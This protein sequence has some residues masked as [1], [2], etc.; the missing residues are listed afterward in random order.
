MLRVQAGDNGDVVWDIPE[1]RKSGRHT[2]QDAYPVLKTKVPCTPDPGARHNPEAAAL[3]AAIRKLTMN[4]K[5]THSNPLKLA[6][7]EALGDDPESALTTLGITDTGNRR[8]T[9]KARDL[10]LSPAVTVISDSKPRSGTRNPIRIGNSARPPAET[11]LPAATV[12]NDS[13]EVVTNDSRPSTRKPPLTSTFPSLTERASLVS[14]PGGTST[15]TSTGVDPDSALDLL[16]TELGAEV[17]A[18]E[19][20]TSPHPVADVIETWSAADEG[21]CVK[22]GA[23][24]QLYGDGG[25]PMCAD[26]RT[27]L[28]TAA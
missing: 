10:A 24:H 14:A 26:C 16:R 27:A 15:G 22:C 2:R 25:N 4:E 7:L 23:P 17:I 5:F 8:R 1:C 11:H 3:E 6:I 28:G 9:R 21:P 20:R 13:P 19:H 18:T 12:T